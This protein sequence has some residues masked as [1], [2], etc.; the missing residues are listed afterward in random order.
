MFKMLFIAIIIIVLLI[1][2]FLIRA[3]ISEREQRRNDAVY[4]VSEKWGGP[5]TI[6]GPIIAIP[7][8]F[9][10]TDDEK[11]NVMK[12]T[13]FMQFLPEQLNIASEIQEEIRS[14]GIFDIVVYTLSLTMNG[15][16]NALPIDELQIPKEDVLW[17]DAALIMSITDMRGL[18]DGASVTLNGDKRLFEPGPVHTTLF[19]SGIHVNLPDLQ[20]FAGG[21][22]DFEITMRLRGNDRLYFTPVGRNT[23]VQTASSWPDPSFIGA[24]LPLEHAISPEGFQAQWQISHLSRNYPQFWKTENTDISLLSGSLYQSVFGVELFLSVDHY[25]LIMRSVKYAILFILLTFAVFFLFEMMSELRIHPFQYLLIGFAMS[26]FYLLLLS[27]SEHLP[28]TPSYIIAAA[29]MISLIVG[30][31]SSILVQKKRTMLISGLLVLLYAC[32]YIL[33]RLE[34]YA[35]LFGTIV[36]VT[37]LALIMFLTR[38]ID[39]YTVRLNRSQREPR[40][41]AR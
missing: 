18:Q 30:Y 28:F 5:Q 27:L 2:L 37:V 31:S 38:K 14:R 34:D 33:L 4:E 15:R 22:T 29:A 1:P 24:Y 6:A 17:I 13:E 11:K 35:L 8:T 32:L 3:V 21:L 40:D 36:L 26:L 23:R 19:A 7:Y 10:F 20:D 41:K 25:H 16:F 12:R 39:W 9:Y